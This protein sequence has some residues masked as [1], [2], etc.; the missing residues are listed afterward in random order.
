MYRSKVLMFWL[1]LVFLPFFPIYL[2]LRYVVVK[3]YELIKY[4]E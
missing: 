1:A 4:Y 3:L 2:L